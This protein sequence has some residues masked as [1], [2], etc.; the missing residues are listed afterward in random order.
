MNEINSENQGAG[1]TVPASVAYEDFGRVIA[2]RGEAFFKAVLYLSRRNSR[3]GALTRPLLGELLSQSTQIEELLDAYGAGN[4]SRWAAFRSMT[5]AIKLFSN[6]GYELLHIQHALAAY[7]LL[8]VEHNFEQCTNQTLD[9][10]NDILCKAANYLIE[11]AAGLNLPIEEPKDET[12]RYRETILVGRL[13]H[14]LTTRKLET[15]SQTITMLSTAFLNLAAECKQALPKEYTLPESYLCEMTG[16]VSEEKL[17]SLEL[18]FHSLQSLYDTYVSTT[19]T[20]VFDRDLPVM[21]GHISVVLHLLR[22]ARDIA[23]YYERHAGPTAQLLSSRRVMV[24]PEQLLHVLI[25]YSISFVSEYLT[26]AELLCQNMLK[27]YIETG[28]IT[29]RV[30]PYRG[31]HVRPSTLIAKLV[32][33]YGSDVRMEIEND[34]YDARSP[35][36]LF[37]AN[38]K[39]NAK[40]RKALVS[41]MVRLNL[42]PEECRDRDPRSIVLGA[43]L[44]LAERGKI[45]IYEQPLLIEETPV[46]T[47]VK[48]LEQVSD[49]IVRLFVTGKIDATT[50]TTT[51]FYGD[52]R[53][54]EDIKLLADSGYGEDKFGNNIP[55]PDGLKHLRQ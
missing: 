17:R 50:D 26:C 53:V 1:S 9:I 27:R 39:I 37:R 5:A 41:E 54:L 15:V 38:E 48:M 52:K 28:R 31:F 18:R 40:K 21:R 19:E 49:E 30:P 6:V 8:P 20:E 44:T 24:N 13:P 36:E 23:H 14:D 55:L 33:H 45:I 12:E 35:L 3:S 22:V 7:R 47:G 2:G 46:N 43:V 29:V 11:E 10:V 16:P 4:N 25:N 51:T 42:V 34:S 32:L